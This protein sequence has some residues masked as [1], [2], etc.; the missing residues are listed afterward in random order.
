M[1]AVKA[2]QFKYQPTKE[3]IGL[4][5]TFR[6]MVNEA[7]RIGLACKITSRFKLIKAVYKN[8]KTYGLH[9]HYP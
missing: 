6:D 7:I 4:I 8:F 2:V 1:E 3:I 9:T 5:K